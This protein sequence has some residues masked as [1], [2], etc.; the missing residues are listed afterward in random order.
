MDHDRKSQLDR[1]SYLRSK[2]V[3]LH[4]AGRQIVVVVE[5]NLADG[6]D[7]GRAVNLVTNDVHHF[8]NASGETTRNVRMNANGRTQLGPIATKAPRTLFFLLIPT[9]ENAEHMR[10]SRR[11][12]AVD[13]RVRIGGE[14]FI[15]QVTVGVDHSLVCRG[16]P[17]LRSSAE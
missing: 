10:E 12:S 7:R 6:P 14:G 2:D 9:F 1:H 13:Y 4:F 8:I 15:G 5:T 3:T 17:G 16:A 11:T